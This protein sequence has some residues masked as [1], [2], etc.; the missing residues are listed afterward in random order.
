MTDE[1]ADDSFLRNGALLIAL[2]RVGGA[3][4]GSSAP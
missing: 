3:A 1:Q 4:P 2:H